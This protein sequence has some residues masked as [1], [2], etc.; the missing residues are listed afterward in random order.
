MALLDDE[1]V[2]LADMLRKF[3]AEPA[4]TAGLTA[5]DADSERLVTRRVRC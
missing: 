1:L 2:T 5:F 3:S 4:T